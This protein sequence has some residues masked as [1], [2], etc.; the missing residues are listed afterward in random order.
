MRQINPSLCPWKSTVVVEPQG[1]LIWWCLANRDGTHH[2]IVMGDAPEHTTVTGGVVVVVVI[3]NWDIMRETLQR[4]ISTITSCGWRQENLKGGKII[5]QN[6]GYQYPNI[7]HHS[8]DLHEY[9]HHLACLKYIP[10]ENI[11]HVTES[12]NTW[13]SQAQSTI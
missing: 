12:N 1:I 13:Y 11:Q 10:C 9:I 6:S 4:K 5:P 7:R 2:N 3:V 8:W